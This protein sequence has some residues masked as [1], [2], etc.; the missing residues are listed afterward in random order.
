DGDPD[1]LVGNYGQANR[2]YR[3]DGNNVFNSVWQSAESDDTLAAAWGDSDNDGDLDQWVG[4]DSGLNRLYVNQEGG[5]FSVVSLCA[6]ELG[7]MNVT[8]GDIDNDGDLDYVYGRS[9]LYVNSGGN[10][11]SPGVIEDVLY[12]FSSAWGDFNNDGLLD[13][14]R[15]RRRYSQAIAYHNMGAGAFERKWSSTLQ[16]SAFSDTLALPADFDKDGDLDLLVPSGAN[17]QTQLYKNNRVELLGAPY[18]NTAPNSP[19]SGFEASWVYSLNSSTLTFKWSPPNPT[20]EEPANSLYYNVAVATFPFGVTGDTINPDQGQFIHSGVF[21]S[22]LMGGFIRPSTETASGKHVFRLRNQGDG[23][24]YWRVQSIDGGLRKS[25]WSGQQSF[26]ATGMGILVSSANAAAASVPQGSEKAFLRLDLWSTGGN[27]ELA[28]VR[29]DKAAG[30][31]LADS[32][33]ESIA[34]YR[35]NN[36]GVLVSTQDVKISPAGV[37]WTGGTTTF[38]LTSPETITT[39]PRTYFVALKMNPTALIG[40]TVGVSLANNTYLKAKIATVS[41]SNFPAVS[42]LSTVADSVNILNASAFSDTATNVPHPQTVQGT[43]NEPFMK[44][45]LWTDQGTTEVSGLRVVR[46]GSGGDGDVVVLKVHRDDGD[47]NWEGPAIDAPEPTTNGL[48]FDGVSTITFSAPLTIDPSLKHYFITADV[49]ASAGVLNT[50]RLSL[51]TTAAILLG[52]PSDT[53]SGSFPMNSQFTTLTAAPNVLTVVLTST[54]PAFAAQ[55]ESVAMAKLN[56]QTNIGEAKWTGLEVALA[57]GEAGA[58][59]TSAALYKDNNGNGNWDGGD[60]TYLSTQAFVSGAAALTFSTQ[61]IL[62]SGATYFVIYNIAPSAVANSSVTARITATNKVTVTTPNTTASFGAYSELASNTTIINPTVDLLTVSPPF[63]PPAP[64]QALQGAA[65]VPVLKVRMSIDANSAYWTSLKLNRA[66]TSASDADVSKIKVYR[67]NGGGSFSGDDALISG[68]SDQFSGGFAQVFLNAPES[69]PV[70]P[71]SREYFVTFDIG[72]NATVGRTVGLSLSNTGY[73]V[74]AAPDGVSTDNFAITGPVTA[75]TEFADVVHASATSMA[76]AEVSAGGL[77]VSLLKL[78]LWTDFSYAPWTELRVDKIGNIDESQVTA[79]KLWK[80]ADGDRIL[81]LAPGTLDTMLASGVFSG[82]TLNFTFAQQLIT[83]S[84]GTYFITASLSG[85]ATALKTFGVVHV[86]N[87]YFNVASPN[88]VDAAPFPLQ[89]NVLTVAEPPNVVTAAS[90]N[91]APANVRQGILNVPVL[92]LGLT[93]DAY[94][95]TLTSL[96][97]NLTGT[98]QS[99]DVSMIKIFLDNNGDGAFSTSDTLVPVNG[100]TFAA[101][102]SLITFQSPQTVSTTTAV[103]FIVYDFAASATPGAQLGATVLSPNYLTINAPDTVSNSNFPHA[104]SLA[105]IDATVDGLFVA[106]GD[107]APAQVNQGDS[108][109]IFERLTVKTTDNAV[110]WQTLKVQKLG[111]APDADIT[112]VSLVKDMNG[113][114]AYDADTDTVVTPD[115]HLF[116]SGSATLALSPAQV[117]QTSTVSYLVALSFSSSAAPGGSVAVKVENTGALGIDAPDFVVN[118]GFPAESGYTTVMDV[119]DEVVLSTAALSALATSYVYQGAKTHPLLTVALK[120]GTDKA[121]FSSLRLKRMGTIPDADISRVSLYVDA[122]RN[123]EVDSADVLLATG[124]FTLKS[125]TLNFDAQ[126]LQSSQRNYLVALD[127]ADSATVGATVGLRIEDPSALGLAAPDTIAAFNNFDSPLIVIRDARTP[128]TPAVRCPS[129][130]TSNFEKLSFTWNSSVILGKIIRAYYAIGT[131]PGGEDVRPFTLIENTGEFTA[132]ALALQDSRTYYVSIKVET[133]LGYFSDVGSSLGVTVDL[134]APAMTGGPRIQAGESS[135][136]LR[137][138]SGRTGVSGIKGYLVEE[139]KGTKPN[140]EPIVVAASTRTVQAPDSEVNLLTTSDLVITRTNGTYFY[141]VRVMNGAGVLSEPS[142]PARVVMGVSAYE[143]LTQVACYPN[144][145]DSRKQNG[146]INYTLK[147][148]SDIS[149][150]IYDVYGDLV[151]EMS[152]SAA[153]PGGQRGSNDVLWDGTNEGGEK[154]SKGMYVAIVRAKAGGPGDKMTLRIG[155]IH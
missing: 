139:R 61:T 24:Y 155:V 32:G 101:G 49:S 12:T 29:I 15:A 142:A 50:M 119:P 51:D 70:S 146:T 114:N 22:P 7:T 71:A 35:D 82:G 41:P 113:N 111:T 94:S 143:A 5:A 115:V 9:G 110:R 106:P 19:T 17:N 136:S 23:T 68:G 47:G 134:V 38:A 42:S 25:A 3:N 127:I 149:I 20:V 89:S 93:T 1:I 65:N 10:T 112:R 4:N 151:K 132:A 105:T 55:G 86:A 83:A 123:G 33:V 103:Y 153:E 59:L 107:L 95:A 69:L 63:D 87:G 128:A 109:R 148:D 121:Q 124:T 64:A 96:R 62:T 85:S 58:N 46:G 133:D 43:V 74:L 44:L 84:T 131:S 145:F 39:T 52:T 144:P 54:A 66:G 150:E 122:N 14:F 141:R 118:S 125:L 137:W 13:L 126:T 76:P 11:F 80:D 30:S 138:D 26:T 97:I 48:L 91:L 18:A 77:D 79:V 81:N 99:S 40:G 108:F 37:T 98:G 78:D 117:V 56:V 2:I 154:V 135:I 6:A 73:V 92:K 21:G 116:E 152:F 90:V 53:I 31:T 88:T 28:S 16:A 120:T 129:I 130:Y 100:N 45:S 8:P 104:S 60:G 57:P 67:D 140:F 102:T 27:V 72:A 75:I 36:D 34:F 147:T